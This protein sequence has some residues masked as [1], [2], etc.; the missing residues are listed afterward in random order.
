VGGFAV[1]TDTDR[2]YVLNLGHWD[3][4]EIWYLVLGA[5]MILIK[6]LTFL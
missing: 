4:F 6:K 2:P 5:L 3:L 1:C